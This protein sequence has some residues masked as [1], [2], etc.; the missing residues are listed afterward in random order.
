MKK[1]ESLTA[2]GDGV[3]LV[4]IGEDGGRWVMTSADDGL[5]LRIIASTGGKWDHVSV[6]R[7]DRIPSWAEM[8]QVKRAF[9]REN[10]TAIQYHV[11]P[12]DHINNHAHCL[13]LWRPQYGVLPRPPR[14]F[15]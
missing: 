3:A 11:P 10:E 4:E 5:P 9:F 2:L 6:S 7:A 14:D 8:E 15:V 1:L 12:A 13:H